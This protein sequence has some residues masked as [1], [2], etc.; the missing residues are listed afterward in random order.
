M[1]LRLTEIDR[2]FEQKI[3]ESASASFMK[4]DFHEQDELL[5]E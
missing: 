4:E 1:A 5:K 3:N 2:V